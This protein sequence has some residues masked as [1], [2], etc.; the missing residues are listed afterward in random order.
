MMKYVCFMG[1]KTS[2]YC[3]RCTPWHGFELENLRI[4][5]GSRRGLS[6]THKL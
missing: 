2:R 6:I 1:E 5:K 3:K 4:D